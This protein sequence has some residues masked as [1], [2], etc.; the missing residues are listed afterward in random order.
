MRLPDYDALSRAGAD[1]VAA[2]LREKPEA[3]LLLATGHTR[4]GLYEV[5]AARAEAGSLDTRGVRAVQLDEYLGVGDDDPRSLYGWLARTVLVPLRIPPARVVWLRGTPVAEVDAA[6]RG[7]DDAVR[8]LGG[9]DL[10]VLG[11]GPNGHLGFNEPPSS[12]DAPTRR[13]A[14]SPASRASSAAYW[15]K[16]VPLEAVTAGMNVIL[17]A[18][19]ILLLVSGAHKREVLRRALLGPVSADLPASWVQRATNVSV[20]ADADAWPY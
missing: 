11:L 12:A 20:L 10:A 9:I 1:L 14:L 3:T 19:H 7:Y 5:L 17:A 18:K 8:A 4:L 15:Q 6:C 2:T 13:V 16:P